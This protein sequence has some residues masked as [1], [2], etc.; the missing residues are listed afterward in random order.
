MFSDLINI[1]GQDL[2]TSSFIA[3]ISLSLSLSLNRETST[4]KGIK[5]FEPGVVVH[6]CNPST[7]EDEAEDYEA[8]LGCIM[9]PWLQKNSS[10]LLEPF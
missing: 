6:T 5:I 3:P 10:A 9:R 4:Q 7:Q 8:D 1:W 2:N